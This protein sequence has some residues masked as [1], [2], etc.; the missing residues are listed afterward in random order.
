MGGIIF[1]Y[2]FTGIM[3]V[4]IGA[5]ISYYVIK[6]SVQDALKRTEGYLNNISKQLEEIK[7]NQTSK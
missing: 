3:G 4:I 7:N 6:I 2:V 5:T 1:A